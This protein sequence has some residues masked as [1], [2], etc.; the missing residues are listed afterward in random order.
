MSTCA[1]EGARER[2]ILSVLAIVSFVA[3][4][5]VA[6]TFTTLN[7]H[8]MLEIG[9]Y[10]IHHFW[11]GVALLA[12]GGWL[13]INYK[14]ERVGR[15]AAILYGAGGGIYGDEVGLILTGKDYWTGVTYTLIIIFLT[16]ALWLAF[17]FRY[18][19]VIVAEFA[20]L[21]GSKVSVYFATLL[22]VVSVAVLLRTSDM[23]VITVSSVLTT[24]SCLIIVGYFVER[25]RKNG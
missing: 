25:Y 13:G 7:P 20:G 15:L 21:T 24:I 18:S 4:F 2:S 3:S 17:F 8:A 10:H 1:E 14:S 12:I 23:I 16:I 9:G 22:A 11:Y 19:R 6:R 5:L